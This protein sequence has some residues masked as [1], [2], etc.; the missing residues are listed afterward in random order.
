MQGPAVIHLRE[1][2]GLLEALVEPARRAWQM[3][4]VTSKDSIYLNKRGFKRRVDDVAGSTCQALPAGAGLC[5][6]RL[7]VR[8]QVEIESKS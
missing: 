4:L 3:T 2:A 8:A 1:Y 7:G 5:L 6:L